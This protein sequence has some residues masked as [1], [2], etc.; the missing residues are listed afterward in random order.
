MKACIHA[1]VLHD[2][3]ALIITMFLCAAGGGVVKVESHKVSFREK[4]KVGSMDN[5][6]HS[7]AGGD[8]KVRLLWGT[9]YSL[10]TVCLSVNFKLFILYSCIVEKQIRALQLK[11][12]SNPANHR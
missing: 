6:S 1:C 8:M 2:Y 4:A 10:H 3:L 12:F 5:L 7:P 9:S 11:R